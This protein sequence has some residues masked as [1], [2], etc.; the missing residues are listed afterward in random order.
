MSIIIDDYSNL[1]YLNSIYDSSSCLIFI[2]N[3]LDNDIS[4]NNT[5]NIL[6]CISNNR[7]EIPKSIWHS[8][9]RSCLSLKEFEYDIGN[10]IWNIFFI[11]YMNKYVNKEGYISLISSEDIS[12]I[13]GI[14]Y[15]NSLSIN[16][17][18][19]RLFFSDKLKTFVLHDVIDTIID[20]NNYIVGQLTNNLVVNYPYITFND[21]SGYRYKCPTTWKRLSGNTYGIGKNTNIINSNKIDYVDKPWKIID[22]T[23]Y[24][25]IHLLSEIKIMIVWIIIILRNIGNNKY[26]RDGIMKKVSYKFSKDEYNTLKQYAGQMNITE[27]ILDGYIRFIGLGWSKNLL[28][29]IYKDGK[30]DKIYPLVSMIGDYNIYKKSKWMNNMWKN[31]IYGGSIYDNIGKIVINMRSDNIEDS[32]IIERD[33][34]RIQID[35]GINKEGELENIIYMESS[36]EMMRW[37]ELLDRFLNI[38]VK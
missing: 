3:K 31:I 34:I 16:N 23:N 26:R 8:T 5:N 1:E 33:D 7:I 21:I 36:I 9:N 19:Y 30:C 14:Y 17:S 38:W 6:L 27:Y 37:K 11:E 25:P 24:Y 12:G 20:N 13:F 35:I 10:T 28:L 15:K 22:N 4:Y 2:D 32:K 29:E 18:E